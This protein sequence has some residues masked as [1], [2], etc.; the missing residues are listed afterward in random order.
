MKSFMAN[1]IFF[2][3]SGLFSFMVKD[4]DKHAMTSDIVHRIIKDGKRFVTTDYIIDETATLLKARGYGHTI[5]NLFDSILSSR[6]CRIDWMDQEHFDSTKAFFLKHCDHEW[7]F[8][9]CFSFIVMR[10][11]GIRDALTKDGHFKEAGFIPL[12]A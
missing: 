3:T 7:S 5:S 12:L 8:T 4:D 6:A 9:D 10:S 2:D 11:A 1:E